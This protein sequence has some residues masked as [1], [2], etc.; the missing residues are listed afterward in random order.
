MSDEATIDLPDGWRAT[1][2]PHDPWLEVRLHPGGGV[3]WG[4]ADGLWASIDGRGARQV[5]LD[6]GEINFFPSALMTE[7]VRLHKRL[8]VAGGRLRLCCLQ[9]HPHEALHM[10][11]LDEVLPVFSTREEALQ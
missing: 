5:V 9:D 10:V 1:L 6:M 7:L 2:R 4:I 3:S 11:R 8:A